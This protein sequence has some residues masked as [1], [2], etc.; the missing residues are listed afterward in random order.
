MCPMQK[1]LVDVFARLGTT[2]LMVVVCLYLLAID[3]IAEATCGR[4]GRLT[5]FKVQDDVLYSGCKQEKDEEERVPGGSCVCF[6]DS[7]RN[8]IQDE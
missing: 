6:P 5:I 7:S 1:Q 8:V 3:V 2:S 4:R